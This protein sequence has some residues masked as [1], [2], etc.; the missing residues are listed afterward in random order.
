MVQTQT[1]NPIKNIIVNPLFV[2]KLRC[3][4]GICPFGVHAEKQ[5][6]SAVSCPKLRRNP[7]IKFILIHKTV[8][9]QGRTEYHSAGNIRVI[10]IV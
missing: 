8:P 6:T 3:G 10:Y 4:G 9:V 7:F 1:K 5:K 2:L